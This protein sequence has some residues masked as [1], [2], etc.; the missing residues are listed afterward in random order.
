MEHIRTRPCSRSSAFLSLLIVLLV[1][2]SE[3]CGAAPSE[4]SVSGADDSR[5]RLILGLTDPDWVCASHFALGRLIHLSRRDA[6]KRHVIVFVHGWNGDYLS[7]WGTPRVIVEDQRFNELFDFAFWGYSTGRPSEFEPLEEIGTDF[8]R[9][10][11]DLNSRYE[12]ITIVAH[13][14]GA[15]VTLQSLLDRNDAWPSLPSY[16]ISRVV[17]FAPLTVN[18]FLHHLGGLT[19]SSKELRE[20]SASSISVLSSVRQRLDALLSDPE[21]S[22]TARFRRGVL[23]RTF[24]VHAERDRVV[25]VLPTGEK[26]IMP[27]LLEG[28]DQAMPTGP[29]RFVVIPGQT[30]MGLVKAQ[31]AFGRRS[32]NRFVD[33]LW[34]RVISP[35]TPPTATPPDAVRRARE[36]DL[37]FESLHH[38]SSISIL[39]PASLQ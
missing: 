4:G 1:A 12:S 37:D 29:A 34:E 14:K 10:L 39:S 21:S 7:T 22:A 33:L 25:D 20:L 17:L 32:A 6:P 23:D 27:A 11:S 18:L 5:V 35:S 31:P 24:V 9:F 2:L 30:H 36:L 38:S 3:N 15:L 8:G 19:L 16:K 26:T 13:S 28:S